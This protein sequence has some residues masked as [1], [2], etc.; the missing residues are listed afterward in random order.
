MA[1]WK[2]DSDAIGEQVIEHLPDGGVYLDE[3]ALLIHFEIAV[4][5][6]RGIAANTANGGDSEAEPSAAQAWLYRKLAAIALTK[7]LPRERTLVV[8]PHR[9]RT[10]E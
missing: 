6:L 1:A 7:V 5:A 3:L 9:T 2:R 4:S 8:L 10:G